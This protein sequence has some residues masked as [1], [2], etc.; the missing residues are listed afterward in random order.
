[1]SNELQLS[2][3]LNV[4]TAEINTYKNLAGEAIFEIGRRLKHVKDNDLAH[5]QF[6]KWLE[7]IDMTPR[8]AQ[9][10]MK[11][12]EELGRKTTPVSHLGIKALY[13]I[14][15]LPPD[16]RDKPHV[17][18]S[19]GETKMVNEMTTRELQEVKKALKQTKEEKKKLE[20]ELERERNKPPKIETKIIEKEVDYTDYKTI[21]KLN[22]QIKTMQRQNESLQRKMESLERQRDLL[23][24]RLRQEEK[25]VEEYRELKKT[26]YYLNSEKDDFHRQIESATEL[27]G[28]VVEIEHLLKTKLAPVKYSRALTE[29]RDSEIVMDNLRDI[30]HLVKEWC[31]E[32]EAYLPKGNYIDVEVI[33]NE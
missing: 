19:T 6:G 2:N 22:N 14:A 3:D 15:T 29:R 20:Q 1:M 23:E 30:I 11:V 33:E 25:E 18:P 8:H 28:L 24:T 13:E 27:S 7:S 10:F 9:R 16:E 4:I 12:Y 21:S 17:I 32:M 31:K 26:M 5:G